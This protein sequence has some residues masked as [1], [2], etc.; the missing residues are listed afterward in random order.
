MRVE[1]T[2][3]DPAVSGDG[4]RWEFDPNRVLGSHAEMIER[5]FGQTW[6]QFTAAVVQGSIKA[7]RVLLWY[8]RMLAHPGYRLE[9]LPEFYTG[10][11]VVS[12]GVAE[13]TTIR[14]NV[15][16]AEW[17]TE[18]EREQALAA[19]DLMLSEAIA[20]A[21]ADLVEQAGGREVDE[22]EGKAPSPSAAKPTGSRRRNS[23]ASNRGSG[24]G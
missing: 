6:D 15:A 5:R 19:V 3:E 2:P 9:D 13:L 8:F 21:E 18:Q 22:G 16:K 17:D 11:L 24:A 23:S 12:F 7:R 1:Y 20:E 14:E 10:E 4:G